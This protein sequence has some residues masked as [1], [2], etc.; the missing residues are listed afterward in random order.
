MYIYVYICIYMYIYM[1]ILYVYLIYLYLYLYIYLYLSI[2]IYLSIYLPTFEWVKVN[3]PS[4]GL[5]RL[6]LFFLYGLGAN[7][8]NVFIVF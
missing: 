5:G 3:Q 4:C 1:Y 2:C 8:F 6:L 7:G